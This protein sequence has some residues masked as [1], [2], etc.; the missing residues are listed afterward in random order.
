MRKRA[1]VDSFRAATFCA[2]LLSTTVTGCTA[3]VT[4]HATGSSTRTATASPTPAPSSTATPLELVDP[5]DLVTGTEL[6]DRWGGPLRAGPR[7]IRLGSADSCQTS[8]PAFT[9]IVAVRTKAG[10]ADVVESDL[11][12]AVPTSIGTRAA[13]QL[14]D[15]SGS[16][17][18]ALGVGRKAR[19]DVVV[20]S[21]SGDADPCPFSVAIAGLVD[22][23]LPPPGP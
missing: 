13:K 1:V 18:I 4:G 16:C 20:N 21:S 23:R 8:P 14:V 22:P 9:V 3:T 17:L 6:T 15:E 7:R 12:R 11:H 19:V 5:C 10:L 2:V